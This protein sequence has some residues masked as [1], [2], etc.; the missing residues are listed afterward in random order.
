MLALEA[1]LITEDTGVLLVC[2]LLQSQ[3]VNIQTDVSNVRIVPI[4]TQLRIPTGSQRSPYLYVFPF[5]FPKS[6]SA[7]V[8]DSDH[9]P[10]YV[11]HT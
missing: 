1:I 9:L 5:H 10:C 6:T 2:N 7:S 3:D 11:L 4:L 8:L